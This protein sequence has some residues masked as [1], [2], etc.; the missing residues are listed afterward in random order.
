MD[1]SNPL[2]YVETTPKPPTH[3]YS[4]CHDPSPLLLSTNLPRIHATLKD[5]STH[6]FG[7]G[8]LFLCIDND[9]QLPSPS[10]FLFTHF[11]SVMYMS[12]VYVIHL[13]AVQVPV[14]VQ[15]LEPHR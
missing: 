10:P 12:A 6:F 3:A 15:T 11:H 13:A 4:L 7:G 14:P 5:S 9:L 1:Q 8:F 2:E